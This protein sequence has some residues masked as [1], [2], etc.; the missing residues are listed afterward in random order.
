MTIARLAAT[1]DEIME[2]MKTFASPKR[3]DELM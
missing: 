2:D 3:A 1:Y